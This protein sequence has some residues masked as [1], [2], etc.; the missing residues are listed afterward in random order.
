MKWMNDNEMFN[1]ITSKKHTKTKKKL[2]PK[3]PEMLIINTCKKHCLV[4]SGHICMLIPVRFAEV[5]KNLLPYFKIGVGP[6]CQH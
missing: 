4:D 2:S 5:E 1:L 6:K 3:T